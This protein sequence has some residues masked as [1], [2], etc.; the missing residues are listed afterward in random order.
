MANETVTEEQRILDIKVKYKDAIQSIA[1]YKKK[2]DELKAAEA[3]LKAQKKA[4]AI[5]DEEYQK[6]MVATD[7]VITQYKDNIRVLRKELQNNLRQ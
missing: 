7:S 3:D 4:G 6:Q 1:S 2:I 5:T